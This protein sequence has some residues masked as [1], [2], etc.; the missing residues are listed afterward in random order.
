MAVF[1]RNAALCRDWPAVRGKIQEQVPG[2]K[3]ANDPNCLEKNPEPDDWKL[4]EPMALNIVLDSDLAVPG[5]STELSGL[6]GKTYL[7][8]LNLTP[9][10]QEAEDLQRRISQAAGS[11][12]VSWADRI[13]SGEI[14]LRIQEAS[15]AGAWRLLDDDFSPTSGLGARP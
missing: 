6:L 13:E 8:L 9:S 2:L 3:F 12:A 4:L 1:A 7:L 14:H 11:I 10:N 15:Y 5:T